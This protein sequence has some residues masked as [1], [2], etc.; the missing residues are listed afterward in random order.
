[1][2]SNVN[3]I[4]FVVYFKYIECTQQDVKKHLDV[5]S[6]EMQM[7]QNLINR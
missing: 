3:Y 2:V 6:C 5:K 4:E 7:N 1:M